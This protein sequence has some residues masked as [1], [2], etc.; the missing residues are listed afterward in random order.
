LEFT[1]VWYKT[2]L[3]VERARKVR[4]NSFGYA[5]RAMDSVKRS[6]PAMLK[7]YRGWL[8][9]IARPSACAVP[10][11]KAGS[12]RMVPNSGYLRR[13]DYTATGISNPV[14]PNKL[15]AFTPHSLASAVFA[16]VKDL[17]DLPD[18]QSQDA[19]MRKHIAELERSGDGTGG[20]DGMRVS[21][22]AK[23]DA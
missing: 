13:P 21:D 19:H 11:V 4:V 2:I 9:H 12:F 18:F 16:P 10:G 6:L 8:A 20:A 7:I 23:G 15:P 17:S 22:A 14:V 3:E 1:K 5:Q